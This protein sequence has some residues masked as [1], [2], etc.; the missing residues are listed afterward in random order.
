LPYD[1]A[2]SVLVWLREHIKEKLYISVTGLE[3]DIGLH[4]ADAHKPVEERFCALTESDAETFCI[5]EP[6]CLYTP[7]EF[8]VL[9]QDSGWEIEE[10][11][12]SAFGN[13]KTICR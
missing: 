8:I 3:S 11:W 5:T 2:Y 13:I 1:Q 6:V 10:C 7:E 12:V 4:Y 9:L